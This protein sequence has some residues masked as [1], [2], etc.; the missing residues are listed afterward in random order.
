M[1]SLNPKGFYEIRRLVYGVSFVIIPLQNMPA[2]NFGVE[3][4]KFKIVAYESKF[5]IYL[6]DKF[7]VGFEDEYLSKGTIGFQVEKDGWASVGDLKIWSVK[8]K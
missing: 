4:N 7:L 1:L 3:K 8:N 6:N 2:F 5:D